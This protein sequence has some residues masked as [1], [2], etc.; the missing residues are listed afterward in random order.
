MSS[1]VE[2]KDTREVIDINVLNAEIKKTVSNIEKL[3][4]EID[5]IIGEIEVK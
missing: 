2:S 3:R 1:Y 4:N 5:N